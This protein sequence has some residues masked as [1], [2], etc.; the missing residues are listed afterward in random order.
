MALVLVLSPPL[1]QR[2]NPGGL[3]RRESSELR[4]SLH[5]TSRGDDPL[6]GKS[7]TSRPSWGGNPRQPKHGAT[8]GQAIN[9]EMWRLLEDA[10]RGECPRRA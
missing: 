8:Q 2:I 7:W 1:S 5:G 10:R 6:G 9:H 4:T 3:A